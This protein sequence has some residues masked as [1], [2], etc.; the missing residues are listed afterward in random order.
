MKFKSCRKCKEN[1]PAAEFSK[2]SRNKDGLISYCKS[3]DSKASK[4]WYRNNKQRNKERSQRWLE[5]NKEKFNRYRKNWEQENKEARRNYQA[6]W[7]QKHKDVTAASQK[8][9]W[10]ANPDKRKLYKHRYYGKLRNQLG[11][12]SSDII[13]KLFKEQ[14]GLCYYCRKKP[15]EEWHLEHMF[16]V[17]RGGF[18]DDR[19]LCLSCPRCNLRKHTKTAE[20]FLALSE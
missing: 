1:K 14:D 17:S 2:S 11:H 13:E 7:Y 8:K 3:C 10:A 4:K 6:D 5:E 16:P 20:E 12:V 15:K 18:H 19:N 9:W